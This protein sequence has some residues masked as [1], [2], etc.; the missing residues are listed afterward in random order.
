M[1]E[2]D[3]RIETL[4]RSRDG[5]AKDA[6]ARAHECD[7]L[8]AELR[9]LREA[10][11]IVLLEREEARAADAANLEY[12]ENLREAILTAR[13]QRD[14]ARVKSAKLHRD[15]QEREGKLIRAAVKSERYFWL[16][17]EYLN[18]D[19]RAER[20]TTYDELNRRAEDAEARLAAALNTRETV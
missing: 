16:Y 14:S 18:A 12:I 17:C 9:D 5:Y 13:S 10:I 6:A 20:L 2:T 7:R 4:T 19:F 1:S 3:A 8:R 11:Q 15:A